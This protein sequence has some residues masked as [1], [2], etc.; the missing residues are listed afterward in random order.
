[1]P[2]CMK[3]GVELDDVADCCPL[4]G[5]PLRSKSRR[6]TGSRSDFPDRPPP[7]DRTVR[8]R[9]LRLLVWEI[10]GVTL[11]TALVIVLLTNLIV[12][13]TVTWAWY[14]MAALLLAWMLATFPLLLVKRPL[15]I[16]VLSA[17]AVLLFLAFLDFIRD[18]S[19]DWFHVIALP[20]AVLLVIVITLVI[21]VSLKVKKKGFNIAAFILFGCGLVAAGL[22]AIINLFLFSVITLSWSVFV[23][24][25]VFF[26]GVFL[27]Y[28]HYR[29]A[30]A[31]DL[32]KWFQ[33]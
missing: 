22:D 18:F 12:D 27:L 1:M 10:I 24:I 20:I 14:P 7:P 4:C 11:A 6:K 21:L 26:T 31:V 3:C 19:I 33:I 9:V 8:T 23:V 15:F 16:P 25:P 2:F 17:A 28:I 32:K 5:T 30:K 13:L 29:L